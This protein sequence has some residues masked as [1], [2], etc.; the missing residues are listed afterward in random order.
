MGSQWSSAG[1]VQVTGIHI[2][3]FQSALLI[4]LNLL[5]CPS[6]SHVQKTAK[7]IFTSFLLCLWLARSP[8]IDTRS[9]DQLSLGYEWEVQLYIYSSQ[10]VTV[11]ASRLSACICTKNMSDCHNFSW[12]FAHSVIPICH[13]SYY[14]NKNVLRDANLCY[15]ANGNSHCVLSVTGLSTCYILNISSL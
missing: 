9:E 1:Y 4:F 7:L 11:W 6:F 14:V 13:T 8:A 3:T 2:F 12:Y 15:W 5:R 10:T